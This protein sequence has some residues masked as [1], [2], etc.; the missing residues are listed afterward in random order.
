MS[1]IAIPVPKKMLQEI[2][3][4]GQRFREAED[5][6]EDFLLATD[7]VF[8]K[9]MRSFRVRH[10]RGALGDWRRLKARYGL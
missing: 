5:A 1:R 4:A 10:R 9:R 3:E 7:A 6:L 2:V 8:L